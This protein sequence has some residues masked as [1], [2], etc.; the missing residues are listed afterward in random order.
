MKRLSTDRSIAPLVA[1]FVPLKIATD[2]P[3][4]WTAWARKYPPDG[5][6]I[7]I[8]Y[9]IR[10]DGQKL[11]GK[12]GALSGPALPQMMQAALSQ[13]GRVLSDQQVAKLES[14][15]SEAKKAKEADDP[16]AAVR[17]LASVSKLGPLGN[18][19]SAAESALEADQLVK[20]L[21]EE[22]TTALD[23]A[24]EQ[25]AESQQPTQ[26]A[27]AYVKVTNDYAQLPT[28]K[29]PLAEAARTVGKQSELSGVLQQAEYFVRAKSNVRDP[30][31]KQKG[32][33]ALERMASQT[34]NSEIAKLASAELRELMG[35]D[36]EPGNTSAT[37]ATSASP[38]TWTDVTGKFQVEA[39][40][41]GVRDG[42]VVLQKA[43][44]RIIEVP[45]KVLSKTDREFAAAKE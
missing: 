10:A 38:R 35:E 18:L 39:V 34:A 8:I 7:P 5:R 31:T 28:M 16:A 44:G 11:Y 26:A 36:Y 14:A 32:I 33:A 23:N 2:N 1:Q 21:T 6:G 20:Q 24:V 40:Y 9:V 12:S 43:D 22:A 30:R 42:K 29:K 13:S 45:L 25:L 37:P 27:L 19:G 17:A 41:Q 3:A 4:S 15:V